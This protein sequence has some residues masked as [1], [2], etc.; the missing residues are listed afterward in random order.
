M[1][2]I[3]NNT[4][5]ILTKYVILADVTLKLFGYRTLSQFR[6]DL[7]ITHRSILFLNFGSK[8]SFLSRG[9]TISPR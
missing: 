6:D 3:A 2:Q 8:P 9:K 7:Q 1:R 4:N 5:Y